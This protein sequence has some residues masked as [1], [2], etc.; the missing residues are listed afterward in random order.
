MRVIE[1]SLLPQ[2]VGTRRTLVSQHFGTAGARPKV[3]LQ[4]SLHADELPGMLAL[5]HLRGLLQEAEAQGKIQGEVVLVPMA[6]PIGLSQT[7]LHSQLG[8]FE[9]ASAENFNRL[10]PPLAEWLAESPELPPQLGPD[11]DANVAAIR[12]A[13]HAA[14][15]SHPPTTELGSLRHTLMRLACDADVALDL[16]CDFEA[17]VHLYTEPPCAEVLMPLAALLGA[18]AVLLAEGSGGRCYDEALSGVWWQLRQKLAA[19]HGEAFVASHP[20]PQGCASTTVELRGQTDV[21]HDLARADAT[22]LFTFLTWLGAVAGPSLTLPPLPCEPTPLA[23]TQVLKA[24][25]SGILTYHKYPGDDVAPGDVV[26]EIID[27]VSGESTPLAAEVKGVL[28][29]R[30]IV[31]WAT[32]GL[33]VAK[34]SGA[35]RLRTGALLGA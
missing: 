31:R 23:G 4:A 10:Y 1:H 26:A 9:L 34:I 7:V 20:I 28:Y 13:I 14:L 8:R 11:A 29:A 24:P 3:V 2:S 27:P 15:D 16:H 35:T 12:A 25:H 19:S 6:N 30:H 32:T 22:G 18:R 33:D 17:A 5:H 21:R